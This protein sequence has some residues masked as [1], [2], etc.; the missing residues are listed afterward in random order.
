MD[1]R[2]TTRR[3]GDDFNII[4]GSDV[5]GS[6]FRYVEPLFTPF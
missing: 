2:I 5:R 6:L 4:H 1:G 3:I